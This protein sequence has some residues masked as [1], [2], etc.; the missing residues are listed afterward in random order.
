MFFFCVQILKHPIFT[1]ASDPVYLKECHP[2][3]LFTQSSVCHTFMH[4]TV[5]KKLKSGLQYRGS[6]SHRAQCPHTEFGRGVYNLWISDVREV[7]GGVYSCTV[8]GEG[9]TVV[10]LRIMKGMKTF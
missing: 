6:A 7:D 9:L 8:D 3:T 2:Y 1:L 5:W 10:T 4:S